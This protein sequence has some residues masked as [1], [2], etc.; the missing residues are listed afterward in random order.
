MYPLKII[1]VNCGE[2]LLTQIRQE[3]N[4]YQTSV[5]IEFNS[6]NQAIEKWS[7][8]DSEPH[9]VLFQFR[10][11]SD[12]HELQCLKRAFTWPVI[13]LVDTGRDQLATLLILANRAGATQV[14]P[15]PLDAEDFRSAL[16]TVGLEYGFGGSNAKIIAVSGVT[17]GCGAT[18]IAINLATEIAHLYKR[19]TILVELALQKGMLATY[20]NVEPIYTLPDL[21]N[22]NMKLDLS[23]VQQA[24]IQITEN[25]HIVSGSHFEITPVEASHLDVL[26]LLDH[27]RRL[28]DVVILDVPCTNDEA[29]VQTLS[30]ASHVVLVAEQNLPSLRSL[31][32]VL[33]MLAKVD[34]KSE[35]RGEMALEVVLNRYDPK[36][37][38]FDLNRLK[39]LMKVTEMTTV[40]NDYAAIKAALN[41]GVP[42]RLEVPRSRALADIDGLATKVLGPADA[43]ANHGAN[44][45]KGSWFGRLASV[46]AGSNS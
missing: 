18:T 13:A 24:L 29:Y 2:S 41:R 28:A 25:F 33:E 46:F 21:L 7:W 43:Q 20:L 15:V 11:L 12:V 35:T 16:D 1:T 17:G 27:F 10:G 3:L 36:S 34:L 45:K 30:A 22:A 38:E 4:N 23:V 39:E 14:V 6:V 44:G 19:R 26:R 42:L 8:N 31:R 32:L 40:A 37:R 5:E 9:L